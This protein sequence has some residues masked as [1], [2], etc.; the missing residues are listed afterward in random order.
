MLYQ[1]ELIGLMNDV[2]SNMVNE[3]V[4]RNRLLTDFEGHKRLPLHTQLIV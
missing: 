1:T 3:V 2:F 4:S